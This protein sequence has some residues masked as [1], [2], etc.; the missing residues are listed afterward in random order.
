MQKYAFV[1]YN[2]IIQEVY[3]I[4]TWL[5]AGES[6]IVRG[7]IE[8]IDDR[9]EFIGNLAPETIRLKYKYKSVEDYL[10]KGNANPIMYI[11]C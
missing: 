5:K 11:N 10:K 7:K 4:K 9:A 2:G 8:S 3:E 6:M 1:V